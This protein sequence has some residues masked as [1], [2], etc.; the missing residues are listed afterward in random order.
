MNSLKKPIIR[1]AGGTVFPKKN[2]AFVIITTAAPCP[3]VI[4]LDF[5]PLCFLWEQVHHAGA[6][7]TGV[8]P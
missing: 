2:T 3:A 6:L 1:K 8:E 5:G 4:R 7:E